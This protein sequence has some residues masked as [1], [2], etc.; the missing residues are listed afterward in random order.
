MNNL[1]GITKIIAT[2][3]VLAA[4]I[5]EAFPESVK[6][7]PAKLDYSSTLIDSCRPKK[8]CAINIGQTTIENPEFKLEQSDVFHIQNNSKA[9][10]DSLNPG[11]I[12]QIYINFCPSF[13]I[14]YDAMLTFS[15]NQQI[16]SIELRGRGHG[17]N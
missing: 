6:F 12:C 10:P 7:I 1:F 11:E 13:I 2:T 5:Q 14:E 16:E 17:G 8:I 9:C 4:S 15:S 3:F